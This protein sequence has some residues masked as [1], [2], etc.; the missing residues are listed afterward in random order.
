MAL[1]QIQNHQGRVML[2]MK[3]GL[4]LQAPTAGFLMYNLFY[5]QHTETSY[6]LAYGNIL[7]LNFWWTL[8]SIHVDII[9]LSDS[10]NFTFAFA[11]SESEPEKFAG[12]YPVER[13]S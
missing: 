10:S 11:G 4:Y 8:N 12:A 9:F 3:Q 13:T 7:Q 5:V 2:L 1:S 6:Y